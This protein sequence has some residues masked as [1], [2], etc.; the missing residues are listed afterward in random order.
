MV[1][2][3][4]VIITI[5]E[6]NIYSKKVIYFYFLTITQVFYHQFGTAGRCSAITKVGF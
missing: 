5:T 3:F 1:M 6:V 4:S 2:L